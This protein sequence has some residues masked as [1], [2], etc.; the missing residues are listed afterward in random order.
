MNLPASVPAVTGAS[1]GLG[2]SLVDALLDRGVPKVYALVRDPST[3]RQDPRVIPV[4]FDLLGAASIQAAA[5]TASDTTVLINNASTAGFAGP[6]DADPAVVRHEMAVNYEGTYAAIRAFIPVIEAN[7]GGAVVN[8]LSLLAL[9][10]T[11]PMTGYSASKAAVHS[12][13]QALRPTLA[14]R[15]ITV[16]GVYPGGID[17]DML[18]GIDAPKT[19][20]AD[21]AD[22]LLEALAADHEDIFPDPNSQAMSQTWWSDPKSFERAF[23][24]TAAA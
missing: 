15:G 20:P 16:H 21:V 9:A 18:A 6:L 13:T 12:L 23:S 17:T 8:V 10:S 4:E 19:P 1:R 22:G 11:P 7:G 3:V 14:Q 5:T 2:R 24:G